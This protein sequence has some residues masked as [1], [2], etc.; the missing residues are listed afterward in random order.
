[1]HWVSLPASG[2]DQPGD[3]EK[4]DYLQ[5][6]KGTGIAPAQLLKNEL[7]EGKTFDV[8]GD[9]SSPHPALTKWTQRLAGIPTR[10]FVQSMTPSAMLHLI[11]PT[12][13][14]RRGRKTLPV[15]FTDVQSRLLARCE[16]GIARPEQLCEL[17]EQPKQEIAQTRQAHNRICHQFAHCLA[18][19][20][21]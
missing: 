13:S 8:Y 14:V 4:Y 9:Q 16:R 5:R 20:S 17:C 11:N 7:N 12:A 1:M 2:G 18:S 6:A 3:F 19:R 21:E 15:P 10:S